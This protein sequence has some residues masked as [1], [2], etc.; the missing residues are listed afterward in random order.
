MINMMVKMWVSIFSLMVVLA[1]LIIGGDWFEQ[2]FGTA[3]TVALFALI[4]VGLLAFS[5]LVL[6]RR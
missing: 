4:F 1:V 3:P 6:K 5:S 2:Q